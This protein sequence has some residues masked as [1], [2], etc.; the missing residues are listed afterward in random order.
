MPRKPINTGIFEVHAGE[1]IVFVP[2]PIEVTKVPVGI[3]F[4]L[5]FEAAWYAFVW[6]ASMGK[7]DWRRFFRL[8]PTVLL[9]QTG[10]GSP[11][12]L[13]KINE[14]DPG[15]RPKEVPLW[16]AGATNTSAPP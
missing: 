10:T 11:P 2:Q 1:G 12:L 16:G 14:L 13:W 4:Q 3:G 9:D 15:F 6:G 5:C 8:F 7:N